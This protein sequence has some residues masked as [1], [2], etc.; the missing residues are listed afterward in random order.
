MMTP[1]TK[2]MHRALEL[3]EQGIGLVS[4]GALVGAVIVN[5]E[6]VVGEGFYRYDEIEHAEIRA[7]SKAGERAKG[8]TVY[9]TLEPCSH[10]GRTGPCARA[11]I[12]AGVKRVV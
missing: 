1:D 6:T 4:P 12:E 5:N 9:T 11:L 3:A 10:Q 8:S 2:H 7:L